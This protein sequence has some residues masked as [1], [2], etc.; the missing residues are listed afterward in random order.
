MASIADAFNLA[1][2]PD[3]SRE[4]PFTEPLI[5]TAPHVDGFMVHAEAGVVHFAGW[6]LIEPL[7]STA[8]GERRIVTRFA[9]SEFEA[10]AL[11]CALIC[12]LRPGH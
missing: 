5:V 2:T 8:P 11:K 12:A 7:A 3:I 1:A 10:S 9:M 6:Q 4:F